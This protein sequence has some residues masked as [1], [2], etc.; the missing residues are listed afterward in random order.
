[1]IK[2]MIN[3]KK[4]NKSEMLIRRTKEV[5]LEY[6]FK[7]TIRQVYYRLVSSQDIENNRSQ[8]VYFDKVLTDYRKENTEFSKFFDD[9]TRNIECNINQDTYLRDNIKNEINWKINNVKTDYPRYYANPND[10]Q[11]K[12]TIIL[13][14]KQALE[15]L[16]TES[17]KNKSNYILVVARGFNSFTQLYELSKVLQ[18]NREKNLYVF[19]DYDDSGMLIQDNFIKQMD[20]F[21]N[22]K[23][24]NINRIALTKELIEKYDIPK[25]PTKK[26]T[27]SSKYNLPYFVELDALNPNILMKFIKECVDINFDYNLYKK[28]KKYMDIRNRRLKKKYFK[29]LRKIDLSTI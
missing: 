8:Y 14:E 6:N 17:L 27:H 12:I 25:N 29:E 1:M 13:L 10:L 5:I 19:T 15:T 18:D 3:I 28:Y 11:N 22:I 24:D 20:K 4:E 16:F 2:K 23:F 9:K 26:T 21:L 7:L